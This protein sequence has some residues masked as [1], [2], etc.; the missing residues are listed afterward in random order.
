MVAKTPRVLYLFKYNK[1]PI[2]IKITNIKREGAATNNV[3]NK[4]RPLK[5]GSDKLADRNKPSLQTSSKNQ[6]KKEKKKKKKKKKEEE[7]RV[8]QQIL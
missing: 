6:R 2:G 5:H 8:I 7:G 3:H 1:K 4:C